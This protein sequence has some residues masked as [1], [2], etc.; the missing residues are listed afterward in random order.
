MGG[1]LQEAIDGVLDEELFA[2]KRHLIVGTVCTAFGGTVT[3]LMGALIFPA[4]GGAAEGFLGVLL[5]FLLRHPIGTQI[6]PAIQR[7]GGIS[8]AFLVGGFLELYQA[9]A[10]VGRA[11]GGAVELWHTQF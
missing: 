11:E 2:F 10:V 3:A 4:K 6:R 9:A 5:T 7:F 1:R 8:V